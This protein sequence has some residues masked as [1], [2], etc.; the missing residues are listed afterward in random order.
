M[1]RLGETFDPNAVEPRDSFEPLP[2]GTYAV[3]VT[4]SDVVAT[5]SGSGEMVKLT[6]KVVEG[7]YEGRLIWTNIN[8]MNQNPT[9]Q[10]IGQ[11]Q[12]AELQLACGLTQPLEETEELHGHVVMAVLKIVADKSGQYGPKN[13]V[14]R[15]MPYEQAPATRPAARPAATPAARPAATTAHRP[16]AQAGAG[17]RPAF[18]GN[19]G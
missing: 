9:A 1:A 5:K 19:R 6:H 15:Y 3:E 8:Y 4:E 2:A 18:L 12:L 10:R 11:Q 16:A 17:N 13:E 7:P 14:A